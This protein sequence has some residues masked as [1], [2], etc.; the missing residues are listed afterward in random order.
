MTSVS[1]LA[2]RTSLA[3]VLQIL[4]F[5]IYENLPGLS[6]CCAA[7]NCLDVSNGG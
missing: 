1:D 2:A 3:N 5:R 4:S 7:R 6:N